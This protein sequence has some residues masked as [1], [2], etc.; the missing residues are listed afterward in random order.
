MKN[1]QLAAITPLFETMASLA[2]GRP[3][4]SPLGPDELGRLRADL[5][6][7]LVG[8]KAELAQHLTERDCYL[9]LFPLVV[10]LDEIVQTTIPDVERLGWP[11]L[12]KEF[13]DTDKGGQLFYQALD[14]I[15][16]TTQASPV[17]CAVYYF[18]LSLGFR[19]KHVGDS[20]RIAQ[21][22]RKLTQRLTPAVPVAVEL[23]AE[24]PSGKI[25]PPSSHLWYYAAAAL[26]IVLSWF[27]ISALAAHDS[28]R[29]RRPEV[30]SAGGSQSAGYY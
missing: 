2:G 12:Q 17:V 16:E 28:A 4:G 9:L 26:A 24:A 15:L 30:M 14:D 27:L 18:C 20:E 29:L 13:F 23:A 21:Y 25:Q 19:G 10:H 7:Q 11:M 5:R 6:K 8:V 3:R 1:V 22:L